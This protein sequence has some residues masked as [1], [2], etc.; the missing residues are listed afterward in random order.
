MNRNIFKTWMGI[1]LSAV[2]LISCTKNLDR[3][4]LNDITSDVVYSTP[5]GYRQAF[6]KVYGAFALTGNRGPAGSGDVQGIDEGTSDFVRLLWWLQEITTDEAVVQAGWNDPGIHNFH[7]MTWTADNP[8]STGLYYR[9]F[10]QITLANEFMR[11]STPEKLSSRG[12][13]GAAAESI[14][15]YRNEARFLRAFQYWVLMDL[16]GN[17]PFVTENDAIG[18]SLPK[19]TTRAELF[20]YVENELKALEND[21]LPAKTN[22]YGRADKAAV[23]ALMARMYLNAEVYTGAARYADAMLNAKKVIDAGYSLIPDYRHLML[24][25][26][27]LNKQEFILT[28]NYDGLKTQ[29]YG[30]TTFLTHA[31][32][33]GS[34]SPV[35]FGIGGG[36]A[37]IRTT[38]SLPGLFTDVTGA[39]DRRAQFYTNG[40]SLELSAEPAP[41][42]TEGWAVTKYRSVNRNGA[43]GSNPDFADNDF[44]LFRLAE[45]YLIYA[46]AAI[47]TNT[48]LPAALGYMNTLRT[49]AY[50]G[51]SGN[52]SS[53]DLTLSFIIDERARELYWECF[54]RSDLIRFNRFVEGSYLWP[55]KGGVSTGTSVSPIRKLFPIPSTDINSNTQL[56]Q[57]PGY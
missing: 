35:A 19:Q 20:T 45:M 52:I 1:C 56:R 16:F 5:E 44:P 46:E 13:T 6:A 37:G 36:W 47:R 10:Y 24:S 17:P 29:N 27:H 53:G 22:E 33:G 49:R 40:Q 34:M 9:S 28:V 57:N 12:I 55:W 43:P 42:F 21:M 25:D 3:V 26:N 18:G 32:V 38:K 48:N 39:T 54:R 14:K 51:S 7:N 11:Q 30:G 23:W 31:S 8:I 41:A 2:V 50:G 15:Q 4:P